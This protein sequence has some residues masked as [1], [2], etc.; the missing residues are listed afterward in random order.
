MHRQDLCGIIICKSDAI[1]SQQ[2][3]EQARFPALG[4]SGDDRDAQVAPCT[5]SHLS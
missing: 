4:A 3:Q 5:N 2:G 1:A